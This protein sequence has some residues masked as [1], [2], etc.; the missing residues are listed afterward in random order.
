[1]PTALARSNTRRHRCPV[2]RHLIVANGQAEIYETEEP[3][4]STG[5]RVNGCAF[6]NGRISRLGVAPACGAPICGGLEHETLNGAVA[7]YESFFTGEEEGFW[8][9]VVRNLR[10]GRILRHLPTGAPLI[11]RPDFKGVG[12]ARA[13]VVKADGSVAWIAWDLQRSREYTSS[14]SEARFYDVYA[15][16]KSGTRLLASGFDVSPFSL[17]LAGSTIYW[18]QGGKPVSAALN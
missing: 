2:G 17:A 1:M 13:I 8:Y 14:S 6:A 5:E 18:T 12:P 7:A 9:V 16:D 10:T 11:A 4:I 3:V 15:S